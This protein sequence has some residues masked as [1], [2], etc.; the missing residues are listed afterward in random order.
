[1]LACIFSPFSPH[2]RED[3]WPLKSKPFSSFMSATICE[4]Q[5]AQPMN[6]AKLRESKFSIYYF[7]S[8]GKLWSQKVDW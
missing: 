1:M 6:Q 2:L 5:G 4:R 8:Y 3:Q 7:F